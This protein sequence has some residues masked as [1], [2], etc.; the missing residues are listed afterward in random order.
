MQEREEERVPITVK[1][2]LKLKMRFRRALREDGRQAT[3]LLH[4]W[5]KEY[6]ESVE[7]GLETKA[8]NPLE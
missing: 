7:K 4:K 1:V 8:Y 2:G 3:G 6:T 5:I